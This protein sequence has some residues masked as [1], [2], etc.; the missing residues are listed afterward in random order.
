MYWGSSIS[1]KYLSNLL[2]NRN[3]NYPRKNQKRILKG[4][5]ACLVGLFLDALIAE[6]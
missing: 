6:S 3:D 4:R 5:E 2:N 1:S